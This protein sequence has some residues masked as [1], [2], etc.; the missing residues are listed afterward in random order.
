MVQIN[1][2][3]IN[4]VHNY[5][6]KKLV[7]D[8]G[9]TYSGTITGCIQKVFVY[10]KNTYTCVQDRAG[11]ILHTIVTGHSFVDGNKRTGLLT[12]CLYLLYNGYALRIPSDTGN[13]LTRM[14][15]FKDPN[16]PTE[17]DA[18]LWVRKNASRGF[19]SILNQAILNYYCKTQGTGYLV[20]LTPII[21]ERETIPYVKSSK[22]IDRE[23]E[24]ARQE[25]G[26]CDEDT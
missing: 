11:A 17:I 20:A 6:V 14:A 16:A 24:K 8:K 4:I 23:L 9:I 22:L 19:F 26:I 10:G 3:I 12:T 7:A 18:I 25:E 21:L 15:D 13:F 2:E 5:V 1:E